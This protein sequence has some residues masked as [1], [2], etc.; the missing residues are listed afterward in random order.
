MTWEKRTPFHLLIRPSPSIPCGQNQPTLARFCTLPAEL[1]VY[2]LTFCSADTLFQL[3]DVSS[4]L[5][6][7]ASKIFWADPTLYFLIEA[8]WLLNGGYPGYTCYDLAFLEHVQ[9]VQIE[10][11]LE[12]GDFICPQEDEDVWVR[13]DLITTF[14]GSFTQR[15]PN[16]KR[17]MI[18]QNWGTPPWWQDDSSLSQP[19]RLLISSCPPML[20]ISALV[21]EKISF[22]NNMSFGSES[23]RW[24]RSLYQI[25]ASGRWV[26]NRLEKHP[27]TVL[28]PTKRLDGPVGEFKAIRHNADRIS[29]KKHALWPL[30]IEAIDR[31]YFSK[32]KAIP[33]VCPFSSCGARFLKA[34]EWTAHAI[35]W[36]AQAWRIGDPVDI[37]PQSLREIFKEKIDAMKKERERI[38]KQYR[39]L[40]SNW[41]EQGKQQQQE[42]ERAW[43]AQLEVDKIWETGKKPRES[44]L[45][46][47]FL[48]QM[49]LRPDRAGNVGGG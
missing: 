45:W 12:I 47:E 14:W 41:N 38:D 29:L 19:V 37:L 28:M 33:F 15:F 26:G 30:M 5:R 16:A 13:Q 31:C 40:F 9:Q 25:T 42:L 36:H 8:D 1:Q 3:M 34:G 49:R 35:G 7:E 32:G 44:M 22:A 6:L 43:M 4:A 20:K 17:V 27:I 11:S 10:Y 24:Y 23:E 2:I 18:N 48:E 46:T 21:L 39:K